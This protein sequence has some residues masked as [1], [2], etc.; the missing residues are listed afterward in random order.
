MKKLLAILLAVVMIVM[1]SA[2][3]TKNNGGSTTPNAP[4]G[5]NTDPGTPAPGGESDTLTGELDIWAWGADDEATA[6]KDAIEVFIKNH[7]NLKVT[8]TVIPTAD[9]VWDQKSSAALASG[10]AGDVMQMSPDWY[11]MNTK[12]YIDLNPLVQRDA[13][14]LDAVITPGLIDRYYD[15]DGKLEGLP[16][17]TNCFVI[18]Y[19]KDM[20]AEAG[21]PEPKEGWTLQELADWGKA[22]AKGSGA[23]QTYAMAKHWCMNNFMIYSMGGIPYTD[24]LSTPKMGTEE[25]VKA[26]AL[27]KELLDNGIIPTDTAQKTIPAQ[28]LFTSGKAAMYTMGGFEA[29]QVIRDA[30][31]N[32]INIGFAPMFS[33]PNGKEINVQYATGWAITKTAKNVDAAW[34]FLKESSFAN[35]EMGTINARVGIPANR[36]IAESV[37]AQTKIGNVGFTNNYYVEHISNAHMNP[38]GGTLASSGNIWTTMVEEVTLNNA[39]PAAVVAK[40]APQIEAEFASYEFNA[41]K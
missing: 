9:Q 30:E 31:E 7:P 41:K 15:A 37:Y 34:A 5:S 19:N 1:V 8:Y 4:G 18:A 25:I 27:Y 22:F 21:V 36:K 16:L 3:G 14:D 32:G 11:G 20:F 33:D 38:F 23:N 13:I 26:L 2:C 10:S 35:D 12:Y 39:D 40:Y 17:H 29:A 24:D 6:R 28:T